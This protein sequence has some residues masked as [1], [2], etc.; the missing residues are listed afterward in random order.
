MNSVKIGTYNPELYNELIDFN[1][2]KFKREDTEKYFDFRFINHPWIHQLKTAAALAFEDEKIIGQ[3]CYVPLKFRYKGRTENGV[4]GMNLMLDEKARGKGVGKRLVEENQ[5]VP[6]YFVF[7]VT[8]H[9]R[10]LHE[11]FGFYIFDSFIRLFYLPN[12]YQL[13]KLFFKTKKIININFPEK[14]KTEKQSFIKQ[15]AVPDINKSC[16]N[17][18]V[19]EFIRDQ[20]YIKWRFFSA[21]NNFSFYLSEDKNNPIYFVLKTLTWKNHVFLCLV[22]MRVERNDKNAIMAI[23]NACKK[24]LK[25]T[26]AKGILA[27]SSLKEYLNSFYKSGFFDF[28]PPSI[29]LTN[30]PFAQNYPEFKHEGI[31]VNM[32]DSDFESVYLLKGNVHKRILKGFI[33]RILK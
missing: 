17:E 15:N 3:Q 8:N 20:N 29:L 32:V 24:V 22:D 23:I 27:G 18:D 26:G 7:G 33:K 6:N 14:I 10:E 11:K 12:I 1:Q 16:W 25:F 9:A 2:N 31:N 21:Y 4:W 5:K 19:V 28:E 30:A 13:I